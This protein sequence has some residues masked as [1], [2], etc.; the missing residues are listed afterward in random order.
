MENDKISYH[1][2]LNRH[3]LTSA[4]IFELKSVPAYKLVGTIGLDS[5]TIFDRKPNPTK[6]NPNDVFSLSNWHMRHV[7]GCEEINSSIMNFLEKHLTKDSIVSFEHYIISR[8]SSGDQ[9]VQIVEATKNLKDRI[10]GITRN[11]FVIPAPTIKKCAGKGDYGKGDMVNAF[12]NDD[13]FPFG[14]FRENIIDNK[15]TIIKSKKEV[16]KPVDDVIDSSYVLK[17]TKLN[18][19]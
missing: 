8:M 10:L 9:T 1:S 19:L 5:L 16:L 7:E 12:I 11:V 6:S 13:F 15:D 17:F 14:K 18:L 4:K 2:F 3:S